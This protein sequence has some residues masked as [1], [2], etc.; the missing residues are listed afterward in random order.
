MP[1]PPTNPAPWRVEDHMGREK[2]GWVSV[3][4]ADGRRICDLFPSAREGQGPE[5]ALKM[6][7]RIARLPELEAHPCPDPAS[8]SR[9]RARGER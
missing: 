9:T 3:V 7:A 6:A 1:E 4:D 8:G 2:K 5:W